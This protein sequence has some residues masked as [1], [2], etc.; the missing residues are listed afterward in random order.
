MCPVFYIKM[1]YVIR[2][3]KEK[4]DAH[5]LKTGMSEQFREHLGASIIGRPCHRA[6][7]YSFRW[8]KKPEFSGQLFRLFNRGQLEENRFVEYLKQAGLKVWTHDV[9]TGR[10]FRVSACG[11]H[12]GGSCD[13]LAYGVISEL[14]SKPL[15]LVLEF[16][17][18]SDKSFTKLKEEGLYMAKPEHF[19]QMQVYMNL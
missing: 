7:W 16:K 6:L 12:F 5:W 19:S 17:T 13:G 9:R 10:Q 15:N 11:G 8:F 18:H 14:T 2:S 1:S 4:I 3:I